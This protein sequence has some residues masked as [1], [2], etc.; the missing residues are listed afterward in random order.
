MGPCNQL[1]VKLLKLLLT[2]LLSEL[3]LKT[4]LC[5]YVKLMDKG[6]LIN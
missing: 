3:K 4:K 1:A 2:G 6:K 5:R